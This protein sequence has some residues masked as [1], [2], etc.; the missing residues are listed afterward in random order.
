MTACDFFRT[1][2]ETIGLLSLSLCAI[3][4][5]LLL[6]PQISLSQSTSKGKWKTVS[7]VPL[8]GSITRF[9]YESLDSRSGRLYMAHLGEGH[10]VVFDT[11]SR[12]VVSDLAGFPHAHGVLVVPQ[13]HNVYVTVSPMTRTPGHLAVVDTRTLKTK[14]L[15]ATGIHPDGLDFDPQDR[16]IFISNEWGRSVSVIDAVT[17]RPIGEI[18]LE[19]EVGN[20]RYDPVSKH[21]F[22]TVQTKNQLD[23]IDPETFHVVHHYPLPGGLYPHG[24]WIDGIRHI[25]FIACE[26]NSVLLLFDLETRKVTGRLSVGT[27]PDVLTYDPLRHLLFVASESG[28]VTV[29][30]ERGRKLLK[31]WQGHMGNRAH[32]ILFDPETRNLYL[33]IENQNGKPVLLIMRYETSP[34][35]H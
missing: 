19:G 23:E 27:K 4:S 20:T 34:N 14:F 8:P 21:I 5:I 7:V 2:R 13:L 26:Q 18:P 1:P 32:V 33:P 17:N 15:V 10:L 28:T 24:L 3:L 6:E 22:S 25:A 35:R 29:L 9:D 30:K 11:K 16:R 31:A 12:K